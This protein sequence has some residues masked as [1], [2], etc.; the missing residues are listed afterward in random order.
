MD[1]NKIMRMEFIR[2]KSEHIQLEGRKERRS[3][4]NLYITSLKPLCFMYKFQ[5]FSY[6]FLIFCKIK[7]IY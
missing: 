2:M 3:Q 7:L 4:D 1:I 6:N 5:S